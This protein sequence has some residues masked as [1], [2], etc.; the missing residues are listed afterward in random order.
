MSFPELL[1]QLAEAA[2]LSYARSTLNEVD[3]ASKEHQLEVLMET[4]KVFQQED[5]NLATLAAALDLGAHQLSELINTEYDMSFSRFVRAYR[6]QEAQ[7]LLKAEPEASVLSI[8]MEVG[9]RSQS[10]FYAA[11]KEIT[12]RSPGAFRSDT[13]QP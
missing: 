5:L 12:G 8:S 3:V 13:N 1:S 9:F 2:R 6:V 4:E 10:N 7:R 11:F